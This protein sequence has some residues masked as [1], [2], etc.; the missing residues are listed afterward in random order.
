MDAAQIIPGLL[1]TAVALPLA[2]FAIIFLAGKW[3]RGQAAI[4]A[5]LAT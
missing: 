2:S 4:V 3:M 1:G 5:T